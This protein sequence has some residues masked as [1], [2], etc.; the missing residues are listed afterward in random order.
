[1]PQPVPLHVVVG[2]AVLPDDDPVDGSGRCEGTGGAHA[3]PTREQVAAFHAKY[4]ECVKDLYRRHA[5]TY[6]GKKKEGTHELEV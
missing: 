1:M 5:E 3:N 4:V 6:Y 2:P